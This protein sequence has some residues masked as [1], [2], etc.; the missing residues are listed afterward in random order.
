[1]QIFEVFDD[2]L[3]NSSITIDI[4]VHDHG[5]FV[6]SYKGK[7][8][9]D[10]GDSVPCKNKLREIVEDLTNYI[11]DAKKLGASPGSTV[12]FKIWN[13]D[14]QYHSNISFLNIC[15]IKSFTYSLRNSAKCNIEVRTSYHNFT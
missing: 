13:Y 1:M 6:I 8:L 5:M 10:K 15:E 14:Y 4:Q 9:L 11:E 2:L 3:Y 12:I 7:I